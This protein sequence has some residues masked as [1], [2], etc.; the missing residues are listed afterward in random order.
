MQSK[1]SFFNRTLLL[2][3]IKRFWP[4]WTANIAVWLMV[5]T[6]PVISSMNARYPEPLLLYRDILSIARAG[7]AIIGAIFA[8]L[9]AMAVWSF[10]YNF[11]SAGGIASLPVRRECVFRSMAAAGLLPLLAGNLVVALV[12]LAVGAAK[13]G[14]SAAALCQWFAISGLELI[15]FY[16]LAFLCAQLTGNI[17]ILPLVYAVLNFTAWVVESLLRNLCSVFVYGYIDGGGSVL[18]FLSPAVEIMRLTTVLPQNDEELNVIGYY[19]SGWGALVAYAAAGVLLLGAA[20]LLYRRRRME[21]AGDVVA[22]KALKPVFRY[23]MCIGCALV[24]GYIIYFISGMEYAYLSQRASLLL[25]LAFMLPC[26]FIGYFGAEMLMQKSFRV[27]RRNWLGF[28]VSILVL[29]LV[30]GGIELDLTGFEKRTPSPESVESVMIFG[31]GESMFSARQ[32]DIAAVIQLQKDIAAN[33][34]SNEREYRAC[35]TGERNGRVVGLN[36]YY[37]LH[38]GGSVHRQYSLPCYEDDPE[39]QRDVLELQRLLNTPSAIENRKATAFPY[40]LQNIMGGEVTA[41]ISYDDIERLT[42]DYVLED[43]DD[44]GDRPVTVLCTWRF[45]PA[46]TY[47]L[48]SQCILPDIKDGTLGR[49]WIIADSEYRDRVYDANINISARI[50]KEDRQQLDETLTVPRTESA[51]D[52]YIYD[53]FRTVPA[54]A[55]VRT[56]KWLLDHGVILYTNSGV[57]ELEKNG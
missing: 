55:S 18:S 3:T 22:V 51:D 54:A 9:S 45:T 15:C 2:N 44:Y 21:T 48:Y 56:T 29:A 40:T 32:E 14:V 53:N 6:L 10:M 8:I 11:R 17:V 5:L 38:N 31:D 23:C 27:F 26:A 34:D 57:A 1:T 37:N 20:M 49:V 36:I 42:G 28:G 25:M 12:T 52:S 19:F 47:E 7:G 43:Y 50:E 41:S 16:G 24:G 30:L 46:E 39:S 33:K 35:M 13:G 4:L